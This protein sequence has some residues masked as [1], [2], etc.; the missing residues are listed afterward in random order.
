[1]VPSATG[2]SPGIRSHRRDEY[3]A[4]YLVDDGYESLAV[5]PFSVRP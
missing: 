5:A 2:S 1:M 4:Q 3:E